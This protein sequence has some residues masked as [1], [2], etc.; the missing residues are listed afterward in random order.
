MY[1][2]RVIILGSII[3]LPIIAI[4][5]YILYKQIKKNSEKERI[6]RLIND[7]L[8]YSSYEDLRITKKSLDERII[9][10]WRSLLKPAGIVSPTSDDKRN[11][12][13]LMLICLVIYLITFLFT[14][15][16]LFG[17]IPIFILIAGLIA[18]CKMKINSIE[19]MVNE[20]VPAFLSA[21]KSNIQSNET[22]ERALMGAIDNT[23]EP[24]YGQLKIVKS[25]IET[26]TFE[27][28]LTALRNRTNNDYLKFLCSCIEL[29]NEVGANLESQIGVIENMIS[30]RQALN[31]KID[32][33]VAENM[34]I[35]YVTGVAIPFLFIYM[36]IN[37]EQTREFWFK[38][39]ISWVLFFL[40]FIICGVGCWLGYKIIQSIRKM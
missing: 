2:M 4:F 13:K 30:E 40:I 7:S 24:L 22:P 34:P 10:F 26:G 14:F 21:L 20:Q 25:L 12:L 27:T 1:S 37:N 35:I 36:Y 15:N 11:V 33:A 23:A 9:E 17:L 32:S 28:A 18:Y 3:M 39:W 38:S 5:G 16:L 31:R 6:N 19:A 29:S 8:N